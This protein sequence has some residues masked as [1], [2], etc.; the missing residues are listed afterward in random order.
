M[1]VSYLQSLFTIIIV[2]RLMFLIVTL[3]F[4]LFFVCV[5]SPCCRFRVS[6]NMNNLV[7]WKQL[8]AGLSLNYIKVFMKIIVVISVELIR[9][10]MLRCLVLCQVAQ[11]HFFRLFSS[12]TQWTKPTAT[13]PL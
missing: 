2:R 1:Q 7:S 8:F 5:C 12:Q 3:S 10:G 4:W 6:N 11:A 13:V 9:V